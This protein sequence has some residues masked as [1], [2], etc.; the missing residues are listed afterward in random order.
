MHSKQFRLDGTILK[1]IIWAEKSMASKKCY[2]V[3][4]I[5]WLTYLTLLHSLRLYFIPAFILDIYFLISFAIWF[6]CFIHT[7]RLSPLWPHSHPSGGD[8]CVQLSRWM[9]IDSHSTT[10]LAEPMAA[11]GRRVPRDLT[12]SEPISFLLPPQRLNLAL[13]WPIWGFLLID[14]CTDLKQWER[15]LLDL[16]KAS[17]TCSVWPWNPCLLHEESMLTAYAAVSGG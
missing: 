6:W 7:L 14:P 11:G 2:R 10:N 13:V 15:I 17:L 8:G 9:I 5:T 16:I 1:I 3:K 12:H 4:R